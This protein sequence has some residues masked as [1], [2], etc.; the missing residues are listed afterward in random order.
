MNLNFGQK[1][2]GNKGT[3]GGKREHQTL[4]AKVSKALNPLTWFSGDGDSTS[5]GW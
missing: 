3:S 4:W 1:K 2:G 5:T